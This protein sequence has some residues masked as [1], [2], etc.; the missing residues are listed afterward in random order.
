MEYFT[1]LNMQEY[2]VMLVIIFV[3]PRQQVNL[4]A[5]SGG[6]LPAAYLLSYANKL[7]HYLQFKILFP[8]KRTISRAF[9]NAL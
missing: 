4:I 3:S 6:T 2:L 8:E 7:D 5:F 9:H 1:N